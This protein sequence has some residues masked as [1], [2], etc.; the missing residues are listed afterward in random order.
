MKLKALTLVKVC[1][2]ANLCMFLYFKL[3]IKINIDF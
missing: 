3:L 1:D 2:K